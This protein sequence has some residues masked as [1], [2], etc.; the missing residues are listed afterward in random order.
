MVTACPNCGKRLKANDNLAGKKAT[1]PACKNTFTITAEIGSSAATPPV[2]AAPGSVQ[3]PVPVPSPSPAA[4]AEAA[5]PTAPS[6]PP[7]L[8]NVPAGAM[9]QAV[10]T[11]PFGP[12]ATGVQAVPAAP[13]AGQIAIGNY[14]HPKETGYFTLAAV[15][16]GIAWVIVLPL[17]LVGVLLSMAFMALVIRLLP[18][19][20]FVV[21]FIVLVK[22][23]IRQSR[24][25]R[26]FGN[27][28]RV[29]EYQHSEI[30]E[31]ARQ[32]CARIGIPEV[33]HILLI[34]SQG[35]VNAIARRMM[36]S[37]YVILYSALVDLMLSSGHKKQLAMIIAHELA[38]HAAG[39]VSYWKNLFLRPAMFVPFLGA[40]YRRAC[41]LTADRIGLILVGDASEA[42]K[43]LA[44]L[45]GGSARLSPEL[46]LEAFM[47]QEEELP[48]VIR[49][50]CD[51]YSTHPRTTMRVVE[52]DKYARQWGA[53]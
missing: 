15:I 8:P 34:N 16:S 21:L 32:M 14:R 18:L 20:I 2:Q 10:A 3:K 39:H 38:H 11:A 53:G 44:Y 50:V 51:M 30:F 27:S 52:L 4:V 36:G 46:N 37:R 17:C 26:L 43:A 45:A 1:C 29:S 35:A 24:K 48:S 19:L 7:P 31:I 33:P 47:R 49:F 28:V 25:A 13:Q 23:M 41:E 42:K 9:P 40:A 12:R 22:W 5:A 6:V